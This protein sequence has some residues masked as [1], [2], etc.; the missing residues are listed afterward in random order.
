[1]KNLP[2][3]IPDVGDLWLAKIG[4]EIKKKHDNYKKNTQSVF[5]LVI[6][7]ILLLVKVS[8]LENSLA[9]V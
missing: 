4:P 6:I 7:I 9:T 8:H 2:C 3:K 1:M 5:L